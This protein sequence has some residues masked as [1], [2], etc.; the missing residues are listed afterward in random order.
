MAVVKVVEAAAETLV[1]DVGATER[2]RTVAADGEAG[3][4]ESAC[5]GWG[6][7]LEL[8]V[9]CDVSSASLGILQD[10][11]GECECERGVAGTCN[12]DG[13]GRRTASG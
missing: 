12:H 5:L 1:E 11:I 7:E 4:D 13:A 8:I 10:T 6:V 2:N 9:C 3:S